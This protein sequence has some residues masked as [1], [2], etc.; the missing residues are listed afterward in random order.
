MTSRWPW[1]KTTALAATASS[2]ALA[3]G[4]MVPFDP[5][6]NYVLKPGTS[7]ATFSPGFYVIQQLHFATN[8]ASNWQDSYSTGDAMRSYSGTLYLPKALQYVN[9]PYLNPNIVPQLNLPGPN[10]NPSIHVTQ[11][12]SLYFNGFNLQPGTYE[13]SVTHDWW[14]TSPAPVNTPLRLSVIASVYA[15]DK[16]AMTQMVTSQATAV[17]TE[18]E[19]AEP[20][21]VTGRYFVDSRVTTTLVATFIVS[22]F[23]APDY[24][25]LWFMP[26]IVGSPSLISENQPYIQVGIRNFMLRQIGSNSPGLDATPGPAAPHPLRGHY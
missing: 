6:K 13:L 12:D 24:S 25:L 16:T 9:S 3:P 14:T 22:D 2:P 17:A 20:W 15:G 8:N 5:S 23:S 10:S 26:L 11:N 7:P 18:E 19:L 21:P 4:A 1:P